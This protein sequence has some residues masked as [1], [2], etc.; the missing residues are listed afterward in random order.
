MTASA[1]DTGSEDSGQ[2]SDKTF[3]QAQLNAILASQKREI[4]GKFEGFDSIKAKAEQLDALSKTTEE[5]LAET[6]S[7]YES[8]Q[9][10]VA[11]RDTLLLRQQVAATKGLDPKLWSRVK[12]ESKDEIETDVADLLSLAGGPKRAGTFK[13]G[14][15]GDSQTSAKERAAQALRGVRER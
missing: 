11:W 10:E 14:A 3:T 13:S 8:A 6:R 12:G 9:S 1:G 5:A 2:D 4:E 15:S 7:R